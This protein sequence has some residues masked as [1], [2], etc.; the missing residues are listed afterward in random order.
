[1][2]SVNTAS[3]LKVRLQET[4]NKGNKLFA[5]AFPQT[6]DGKSSVGEFEC[7]IKGERRREVTEGL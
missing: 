2:D 6:A 3:D 7:Q 5:F 4:S 1:M